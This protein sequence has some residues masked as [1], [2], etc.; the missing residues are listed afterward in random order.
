MEFKEKFDY[1]YD[2]KNTCFSCIYFLL[3]KGEV[4]YVG[5]SSR[6][7]IRALSHTKDK[8]FDEIKIISTKKENLDK[9]EAFYI[10]KYNPKYNGSLPY[11]ISIKTIK[12]R[13]IDID[14]RVRINEI[15]KFIKANV[16]KFYYYKGGQ[17]ISPQDLESCI[18]HFVSLKNKSHEI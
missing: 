16:N 7:L 5:Q 14:V 12:R 6:G 4:C 10:L 11:Y 9:K 2:L 3:D 18:N 1:S 13:L 17:Y 15:F 8:D